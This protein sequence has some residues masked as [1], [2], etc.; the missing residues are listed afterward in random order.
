MHAR[1]DLDAVTRWLAPLAV[2]VAVTLCLWLLLKT[3][4]SLLDVGASDP[5]AMV[6]SA[7]PTL[8]QAPVES[9]A[10]WH[11]F[12]NA[13]QSVDARSVAAIDAPKS[14]L[15]LTLSG[16]VAESDP[17]AGIAMIV[18][19][20]GRQAAYR[21]GSALPGGARLKAVHADHV[22]IVHNGRDESLRLPR[23]RANA[24]T[25]TSGGG[26]ST[27]LPSAGQPTASSQAIATAPVSVAGLE[28]VDWQAVQ[29]QMQID[30]AELARQI[31][32]LPVIENGQMVGVRLGGGANA[33]LLGKLGL[34]PD[35]VVTAVNGI[36]VRDTGR[37]QQVIA[38]VRDAQSARVTVRRNGRE[39]T[40]DVSLK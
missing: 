18:E 22:L 26:T 12:G 36:S 32:V 1:S 27:P 4:M 9:L 40:L 38:A 25:V 6:A 34:R 37:A 10:G 2:A 21:V 15:D 23:A 29:Q 16:I 7:A 5:D 3:S 35:D 39:E 30:P 24:A 20:D 33:A 14:A 13:L 11:L 28:T 17:A 19:P 8:P 31:R